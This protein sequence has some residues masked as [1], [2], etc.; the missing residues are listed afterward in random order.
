MALSTLIRAERVDVGLFNL[1]RALVRGAGGAG[2]RLI[3]A[4][5]KSVRPV[6]EKK[7]MLN[8]TGNVMYAASCRPPDPIGARC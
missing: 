6:A 4:A 3:Q 1:G 5:M 2:A 8:A 7:L